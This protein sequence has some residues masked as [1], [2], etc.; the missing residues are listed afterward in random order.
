[1]RKPK[2]CNGCKAFYQSQWRYNCD[3]GYELK[4]ERIGSMKG[5]DILRHSPACGQCPKPR[6]YKELFNAPRADAAREGG[7][8]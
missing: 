7:T 5:V 6:T 4:S 8:K 2:N 1:M 3:L